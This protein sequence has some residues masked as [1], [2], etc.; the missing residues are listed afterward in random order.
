[1][2]AKVKDDEEAEKSPVVNNDD[3]YRCLTTHLL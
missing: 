2:M 3:D 1:M